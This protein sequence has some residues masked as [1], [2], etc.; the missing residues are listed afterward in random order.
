VGQESG[1]GGSKPLTARRELPM[2]ASKIVG[3]GCG[4]IVVVVLALVVLLVIRV[5]AFAHEVSDAY[6]EFAGDLAVVIVHGSRFTVHR[7]SKMAQRGTGC[8]SF[9]E[10]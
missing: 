1:A 2:S 9:G 10:R 8:W 7:G 3:L 6:E 4:S 5:V